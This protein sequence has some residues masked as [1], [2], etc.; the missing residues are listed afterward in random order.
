MSTGTQSN[1]DFDLFGGRN[2]KQRAGVERF[3]QPCVVAGCSQSREFS[4]VLV[5]QPSI[6][7][8]FD[9]GRFMVSDTEKVFGNM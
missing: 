2:W 6:P 1:T 9:L 3:H 8:V 7:T 4:P 5:L